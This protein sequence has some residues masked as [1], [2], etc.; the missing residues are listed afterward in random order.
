MMNLQNDVFEVKKKMD[1]VVGSHTK[2]MQMIGNFM[3]TF[4]GG[5]FPAGLPRGHTMLIDATGEE[6]RILFEYCRDLQVRF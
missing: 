2:E 1:M 3:A 5:Q 6:H 4:E